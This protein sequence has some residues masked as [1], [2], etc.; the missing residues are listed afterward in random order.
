[1]RYFFLLKI[2]ELWTNSNSV[3][4]LRPR[5]ESAHGTRPENCDERRN[6]I[7]WST[8]GEDYEVSEAKDSQ[9]ANVTLP[10][11]RRACFEVSFPIDQSR[12]TLN[13]YDISGERDGY[14][15]L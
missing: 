6:E 15:R 2:V 1:M 10:G 8:R 7:E 14:N 9:T 13:V 11:A 5:S 12:V 4:Y 3:Q